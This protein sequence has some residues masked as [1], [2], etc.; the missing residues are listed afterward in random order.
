[1]LVDW[2]EIR[3]WFYLMEP[4]RLTGL[5]RHC[6]SSEVNAHF[7]YDYISYVP[8][9]C[10]V[11]VC[12]FFGFVYTHCFPC[13]QSDEIVIRYSIVLGPSELLLYEPNL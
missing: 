1:M 7:V 3:F 2:H 5:E 4:L 8:R 13:R 11:H 9:P 6:N 12:E 10:K